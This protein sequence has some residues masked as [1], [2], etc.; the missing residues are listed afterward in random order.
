MEQPL[1]EV[2]YFQEGPGIL[3]KDFVDSGTPIVRLAGLGGYEVTLK[4]CNHVADER[5]SSK[6]Q[7]FKLNLGD[8]LVSTSA[9]FGRPA[10]VGSEAEDAIFYTG[11]IRFRTKSKHLSDGYLKLFLGSREFILQAEAHASGS[12]IR[13]FGPSHLRQMTIRIPPIDLQREI[14]DLIGL[15]DDKIELNRRMNETLEVMARAI[16][17]DW[18]VDFGP[19]RAK[20]EGHAPYLTPELW[21]LFPDAL[22]DGDKPIGWEEES[23]FVQAHWVNGAAYKNMHF[24]DAPDALPVIKIAELKAGITKNTKFTNT[25]LNDKF[26]ITNGELLFSWSGNP[27]TSIDTFIWVSGSA[28]LNQHIFAVRENGKRSRPFLYAMLKWLKPE[29]A[30]IARN[31]QTTGLGHVT[32]QDLKRLLV[33]IGSPTV[34]T[35]FDELMEPTYD[36]I[37]GNLMEV[38]VLAQTRDLL[39][40][41]LMSGEIRLR[42]AEE[43]VEAVA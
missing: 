26:R 37:Q 10:V 31:K 39:I 13:H 23:A 38:R 3:A 18:F 7:H 5:A 25:A 9:S 32:Q 43:A 8:I 40:P 34:M 41:K 36:R 17:K 27:D 15:L 4:G 16:F 1:H 42:N 20:V 21:E 29:F 22:D 2:A 19:T 6:W 11:I 35:A 33:H 12:V 14:V 28:W 24:T 30:E